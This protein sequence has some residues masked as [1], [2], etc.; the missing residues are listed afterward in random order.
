MEKGWAPI[1]LLSRFPTPVTL[2]RLLEIQALRIGKAV[3][4]RV[5]TFSPR[6]C[7]HNYQ[8]LIGKTIRLSPLI[9]WLIIT[10]QEKR[11]S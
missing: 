3:P 8:V 6:R 4:S 1:L 11:E 5:P 9:E 7:A 10:S 2:P